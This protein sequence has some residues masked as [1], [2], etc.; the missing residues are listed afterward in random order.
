MPLN[1]FHFRVAIAIAGEVLNLNNIAA[2]K[3]TVARPALETR[4]RL[5]AGKGPCQFT[6]T[7]L[8]EEVT[9]LHWLQR[10]ILSLG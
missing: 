2:M 4:V 3:G 5:V 10:W 8:R 9:I 7:E 6:T 1:Y